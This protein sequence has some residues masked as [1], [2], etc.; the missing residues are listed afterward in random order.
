M[1]CVYCKR[2]KEQTW[3]MIER[4]YKVVVKRMTNVNF[5]FKRRHSIKLIVLWK[6]TGSKVKKSSIPNLTKA[7]NRMLSSLFKNWK[8]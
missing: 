4:I 7:M 5:K 6:F 1:S 2:G 8:S 3:R